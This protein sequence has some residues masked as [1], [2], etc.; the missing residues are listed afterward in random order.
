ML[1]SRN[2]S[3]NGLQKQSALVSNKKLRRLTTTEVLTSTQ[4]YSKTVK[5]N[6]S[7]EPRSALY[8]VKLEYKTFFFLSL[9]EQAGNAYKYSK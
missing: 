6:S 8:S 3:K 2:E 4:E 5:K 1:A 9:W 7:F